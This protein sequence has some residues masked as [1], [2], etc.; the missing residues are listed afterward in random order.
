[1]KLVEKSCQASVQII[2]VIHY[3]DDNQAM[4]N[5]ERA[6]EA[7]CDGV[8]LIEMRGRNTDL[9]F[10]GSAIKRRWPH[11]HVGINHLNTETRLAVTSN[12]GVGVD[13]TWTDEQLTH[14]SG[15]AAWEAARLN[16]LLSAAP[17]TVFCAVAFKYQQYEPD[18]CGAARRA[19]ALGF[20]PTT[21]GPATGCAADP[22]D[23]AVIRDAIG[24]RAP[25]AIASGITPD[26]VDAFLPFVSHILVSTGVSSSFHEFDREKLRLLRS[27]AIA[28]QSIVGET[29]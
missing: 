4:R 16:C 20:I 6:I 25:L 26:N 11:A 19:V 17:H 27:A 1:V 29:A 9:L 12:I 8:M 23:L 10:A 13:S 3:A 22:S 18:P 7:G 2:P 24:P 15:S 28:A 21:S 14:T 5:A